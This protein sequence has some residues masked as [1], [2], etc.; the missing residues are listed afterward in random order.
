MADQASDNEDVGIT[1]LKL[2]LNTEQTYPMDNGLG[3]VVFEEPT[4]SRTVIGIDP[5]V[6][7]KCPGDH[8][9]DNGYVIIRILLIQCLSTMR[10]LCC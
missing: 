2:S 8:Q 4:D 7:G 9:I 6:G 1:Q 3:W 10:I 5:G